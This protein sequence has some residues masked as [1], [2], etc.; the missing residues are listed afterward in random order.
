MTAD[1][2]QLSPRGLTRRRRVAAAKRSWSMFRR[3]RSGMLGL[4]ILFVFA[5]VALGAPLLAD[6]EGLKVTQATGG[7]LDAPSSEFWLGTDDNGRSVLT[8][9]IWARCS[10]ASPSGSS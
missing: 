3:H 1:V 6:A 4:G 10:T 9:L 7:E 8:L 5:F 2:T